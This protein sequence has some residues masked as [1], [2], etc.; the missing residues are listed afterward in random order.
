MQRPVF[1]DGRVLRTSDFVAEQNYHL[2]AVRRHNAT[3]HVW[4]IAS[5]LRILLQEGELV[6]EKGAAIDGFGRYVVLD[7]AK[8]LDLRSWRIQGIDGVDV[9][10]CY[11]QRRTQATG[12]GVDSVTDAA[13]I[14]CTAAKEIDPRRPDAVS[15]T[16]LVAG[17]TRQSDDLARRWPVYLGRITFDAARPDAAPT[18]GMDRRATL[19]VVGATVRTPEGFAWLALTEDGNPAVQV[20]LPDRAGKPRTPLKVS[21]AD[22]VEIDDTLTVDGELV[23]KGGSLRVLPGAAALGATD[24]APAEW[25]LSHAVDG[26]AHDLRVALPAT[27]DDSVPN[28]L[29]VGAWRDGRFAPSLEVD[30]N[31]TL[32]VHGNLVV[33]GRLQAAS[34]Q[35]AP[36]SEEARATLAGVQTAGLLALFDIN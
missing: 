35:E 16:D 22:G 20:H 12:D 6:V 8:A 34:V 29:V 17:A 36:L 33:E 31:G 4:G 10:A 24:A 21:A 14:E 19:G 11:T 13:S 30:V 9:W 26:V 23:L 25:S 18:I 2:D 1:A 15:A 7:T 5:G 27:V 28:R 32:T 3:L